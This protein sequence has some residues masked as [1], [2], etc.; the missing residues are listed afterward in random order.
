MTAAMSADNPDPDSSMRWSHAGDDGRQAIRAIRERSEQWNI[1]P[2]RIG[3]VGFSAGGFVVNDVA[4]ES[5][6]SSRP[7]FA[8]S[9]YAGL[10]GPI[11]VPEDAPP[12]F[13]A[14]AVDD[15]LMSGRVVP[16]FAAWREAGRPVELNTYATAGYGFGISVQNSTSDRWIDA[17]RAWL[18]HHGLVS[19]PRDEDPS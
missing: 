14:Y 2:R 12:L 5:D 11:T 10:L 15:P 6:E 1:D 13:I 7:D 19:D 17:F 3:I 16:R 4:V 8:A 18:A 9:I